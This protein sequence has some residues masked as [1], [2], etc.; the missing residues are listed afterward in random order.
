MISPGFCITAV[1]VPEYFVEIFFRYIYF[2]F[3]LRPDGQEEARTHQEQARPEERQEATEKIMTTMTNSSRKTNKQT[4]AKKPLTTNE[5]EHGGRFCG[6]WS[7]E[8]LIRAS[9]CVEEVEV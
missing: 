2:L 4:N 5:E 6:T 7:Q 8:L 1:L 9:L 3:C